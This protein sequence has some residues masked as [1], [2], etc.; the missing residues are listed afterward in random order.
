MAQLEETGG[1]HSSAGSASKPTSRASAA[2][3]ATKKKLNKEDDEGEGGQA[4]QVYP[5]PAPGLPRSCTSFRLLACVCTT[6]FRRRTYRVPA[7]RSPPAVPLTVLLRRCL[8][9]ALL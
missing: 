7:Q 4:R 5:R 6:D 8:G 1:A 2:E 9:K 3:Q